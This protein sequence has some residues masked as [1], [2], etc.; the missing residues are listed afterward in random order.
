MSKSNEAGINEALRNKLKRE[1][2]LQILE[3]SIGVKAGLKN[4]WKRLMF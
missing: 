2:I 4:S 1:R 3:E